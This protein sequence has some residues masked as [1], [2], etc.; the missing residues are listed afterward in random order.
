MRGRDPYYTWTLSLQSYIFSYLTK[1]IPS[2]YLPII[3]FNYMNTPEYKCKFSISSSRIFWSTHEVCRPLEASRLVWSSWPLPRPIVPW[4]L[5]SMTHAR[6]NT[7]TGL[8]TMYQS[9]ESRL[10]A[11]CIIPTKRCIMDQSQLSRM[12]FGSFSPDWIE[13]EC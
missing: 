4:N 3:H 9:T 5:W 6:R 10:S 8:V 1:N 7:Y 13:K 12:H 2:P 11:R